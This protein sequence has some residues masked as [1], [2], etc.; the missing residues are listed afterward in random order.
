MKRYQNIIWGSFTIVLVV[1]LKQGCPV[2][3]L[4]DARFCR[5]LTCFELWVYF[6]NFTSGCNN[7]D[8]NWINN[9]FVKALYSTINYFKWISEYKKL[10]KKSITSNFSVFVVGVY[11]SLNLSY[12]KVVVI[13]SFEQKVIFSSFRSAG[14]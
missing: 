13:K 11:F 1:G 3:A 5:L 9:G 6:Q 12:W 14:K 10:D 7:F 8:I 4:L 2:V